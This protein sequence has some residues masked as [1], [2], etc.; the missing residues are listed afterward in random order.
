MTDKPQTT[1]SLGERADDL[2]VE[3]NNLVDN[4]GDFDWQEA[5]RVCEKH[6]KEAMDAKN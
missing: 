1:K 6:L 3:L 2:M 5:C 4:S